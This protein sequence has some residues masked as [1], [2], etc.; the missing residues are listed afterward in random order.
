MSLRPCEFLVR[1]F[2]VC[3]ITG[4]V[5]GDGSTDENNSSPL[6]VIQALDS[7]PDLAPAGQ[8][9]FD[10][11]FLK[12]TDGTA[13]YAIP[14]PFDALI[15]LL[16][17]QSDNGSKPA[18]SHTLIPI[19]RSLQREA[20]APDYFKS[21]RS[22]I[23]IAGEPVE[24]P[25]EVSEVMK[26]RLFIGH[27]AK[28][29]A[30]EVISY[31]N[32][33]G[34]FE[35]QV[36]EDYRADAKPRVRPANRAIC[37]ACHQNGGPIFS[38]APWSETNFNSDVAF[39]LMRLQPEKY[40]S[41][42]DTLSGDAEVMNVAVGFANYLA[43]SQ[44]FW[45]SGC[46]KDIAGRE[47]SFR[48]RAAI[49][50]ALLQYRLSA[51]L[52]FDSNSQEYQANFYSSLVQNWRELWPNG[53]LL[54]SAEIPDRD[55]FKRSNTRLDPMSPRPAHAFWDQ[56]TEALARGTVQRLSGFLTRSDIERLDQRLLELS[57]QQ[58]L[59]KIV[60]VADCKLAKTSETQYGLYRYECG[61]HSPA[62]SINAVIEI[63]HQKAEFVALDI[64]KLHLPGD[65][66]I[67][68]LGTTKLNHRDT[69]KTEQIVARPTNRSGKLS[70][71]LAT[72]NR[73]SEISLNWQENIAELEPIRRQIK[74]KLTVIEDFALVQDALENMVVAGKSGLSSALSSQPFRRRAIISDLEKHLGN[75]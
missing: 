52:A 74:L 42:L 28:A 58:E 45:R 35:F 61:E 5:F 37:M 22:I 40:T 62:D 17:R 13:E 36:V 3:L 50:Q 49:L 18:V 10:R 38:R 19:G 55:P 69:G 39:E 41:F 51:E 31:N 68:K 65:P 4:P 70:P 29:E 9:L 15:Q 21:P 8:S 33:A 72:G 12:R 7:R 2:I 67:L 34:R 64:Q 20:A 73:I 46:G 53:L 63:S 30:M 60:Y 24:Q 6:W 32:Q 57:R 54:A 44:L 59:E 23:S 25:G 14:Y 48:C 75:L 26:Y 43:P 66:L 47:T 16:E 11:V 71:R 56:P 1:L 27:Q